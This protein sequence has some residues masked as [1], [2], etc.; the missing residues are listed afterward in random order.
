MWKFWKAFSR[1]FSFFSIHTNVNLLLNILASRD[2]IKMY[3][4]DLIVKERFCHEHSC[5]L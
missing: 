3:L 1:F 5:L 2:K 4:N